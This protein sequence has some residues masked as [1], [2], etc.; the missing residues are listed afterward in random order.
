MALE[1]KVSGLGR[2]RSV[3]T[4]ILMYVL[5]I[6]IVGLLIMAGV[7]FRYVGT[8]FE[9]QITR[10]TTQVVSE[11]SDSINNWLDKRRLETR[12]A[13]DNFGARNMNVEMLNRN[14]EYRYTLME[15]IYPGTYD[16]VSWGPF[17]GSG[18]LYGWTAGG[19]KE[20]HNKDKAWY[21]E[22]M[23][24]QHESFFSTPV[25]SQASGKVIFNSISLVKSNEGKTV[26]M[27]L[28]AVN[29]EALMQ[30][31][32]DFKLG[33]HG[34]SLLVAEDGTFLVSPNQDDVM[35][36][37]ITENANPEIK[38]LGD[39]MLS[40]ETGSVKFKDTDGQ[41]KIAFYAPIKIAGWGLATVADQDEI[42]APVGNTLK[43]MA[44]ISL[45][46]IVLISIAVL[47]IVNRIMK[48]LSLMMAEMHLM[49]ENDLRDRPNEVTANNELG[50]L[51]HAM[52]DMRHSIAQ[53]V[54]KVHDSSQTLA[55]SSEELNATT[56][57]SAQ[58]SNQIA[59]SI[60]NVAQGTSEQLQAV[61]GTK[62]AVS[63]L[64]DTIQTTAKSASDAAA[65]GKQ[66]ADIARDG[67]KV[68]D[69][70]IV[71]IKHIEQ[72][73]TESTKV[74]TALGERSQ[75]IG[76]IVDTIAGIAD[77]T[78]LLALNAAIEAA[79]AGEQ[80]AH[81]ITELIT[82]TRQDTENAVAG[83]QQ[84][85]EEVKVGTQKI[86]AMGEAFRRIIEIVEEVSQ[87]VQ[88]ISQA[89]EGMAAAGQDI[90]GHVDT[91]TATSTKAAQESE[92]VSAA[93]EEQS[94]S[95][96]EIA[97]ASKSL[98]EMATELQGEVSRFK[99]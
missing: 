32:N 67:G 26:G 41:D 3:K 37:K 61:E 88:Q 55:A 95:V 48:P 69:E 20:M 23:T 85:S 94:A 73:T 89:I 18:N 5:P 71:Q 74:V 78:N 96:Q 12:L 34:Y 35:K 9:E 22:T 47:F 98:A 52:V 86:M 4:E 16:S 57:Q 10:D 97:N 83:M 68:L 84:G 43:I 44:G 21:K 45:V 70:A 1:D 93:T 46:L 63:E 53:T 87:Q 91:I 6:V 56:D 99:L 54:K 8:T 72:S 38:A 62:H 90:V 33:E 66:A 58:A 36:A 75:E 64:N 19:F 40:G 59:D 92:T 42:F 7:T 25:I 11:M 13:A 27:I 14:I 79:R 28:A 51:S 60:V 49:A 77:Q 24:G 80:A 30:K 50:R 81:K 76:E 2:A 39:K 29:L 17:D 31:V 15:K 82:A 65:H